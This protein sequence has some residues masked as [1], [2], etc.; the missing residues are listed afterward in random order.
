MTSAVPLLK[1]QR[2]FGVDAPS[3]TR[4]MRRGLFVVALTLVQLLLVVAVV[5]MG[6]GLVEGQ[7]G[8]GPDRPPAPAV[9][10]E[11]GF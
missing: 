11:P 1:N 7:G 3:T 2:A 4:A 8:V 5:A 9:H 6:L 10:P